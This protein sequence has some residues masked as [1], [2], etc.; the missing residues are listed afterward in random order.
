MPAPR[1][2]LLTAL[3]TL[4]L[5]TFCEA[6][7]DTLIFGGTEI[8]F[9]DVGWYVV[10]TRGKASII[11]E[12]DK[13][14]IVEVYRLRKV[15]SA[16]E[17]SVSK[18]MKFRSGITDVDVLG[19]TKLTQHGASGIAAN[20]TAKH[21]GDPV[22][23]RLT[24]IPVKNVALVAVAYVPRKDE[25]NLQIL[26][27]ALKSIKIHRKSADSPKS[28]PEALAKKPDS[29]PSKDQKNPAPSQQPESEPAATEVL[30]DLRAGRFSRI[31]SRARRAVGRARV[32][33]R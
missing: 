4:F 21:A 31:R 26:E 33:K 17:E 11:N 28:K 25:K 2:W 32:R 9:P 27:T 15:P 5:G 30:A 7:A 24:G 10:F 20:G 8:R 3:A 29:N 14:L 23:V 16:D 18:V 13:R 1:R 22:H 19:V 6:R 12:R